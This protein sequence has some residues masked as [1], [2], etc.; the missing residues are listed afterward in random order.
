[1]QTFWMASYCSTLVHAYI[2]FSGAFKKQSIQ[3][4]QKLP[5]RVN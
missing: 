3:K 2:L 5:D 4:E 1:M